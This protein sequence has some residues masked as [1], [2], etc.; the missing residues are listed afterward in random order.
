MGCTRSEVISRKNSIKE[1]IK[2]YHQYSFDK[3]TKNKK[4]KDIIKEIDISNQWR[5][6]YD[7]EPEII[8]IIYPYVHLIYIIKNKIKN[9]KKIIRKIY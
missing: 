9:Q 6:G 7:S 4:Y 8:L 5:K 3:S 1:I 2:E